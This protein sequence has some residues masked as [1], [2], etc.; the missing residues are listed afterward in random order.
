MSVGIKHGPMAMDVGA[1]TKLICKG[2]AL[3]LKATVN[4]EFSV[5]SPERESFV[6]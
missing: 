1:D 2:H 4:G 5:F 6:R 3:Q